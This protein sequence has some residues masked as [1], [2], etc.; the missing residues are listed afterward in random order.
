MTNKH[1]LLESAQ[2][3]LKK[4]QIVKAIKDY[5]KIV[6]LDPADIRS[7]QKLAELY[8]RTNKNMEAY[9][10]YEPV[11][12]HFA[13]NGFYLKAIAIYKQ[14]QRLDPSQISL[15][16]R[17]AELNHK[18]GLL[19][20]ALS[21]YRSLV[22]YYNRNGMVADEIKTLEKMRDLDP[23]NL[24][25]RVKLAEI[26]SHN[27]RKGDGYAEL[28]SVLEVLSEKGGVDK[29][30]RLYKMFL[31]VYPKDKKLQMGL[32]L[33]FYEKG[34]PGRGVTIIESLLK[35]K[36][37]DP[38]L[39]RLLGQGYSDLQD[40]NKTCDIYQQLLDMD[41]TDLNIR[42]AMIKCEIDSAQYALALETLE[43][44]KETFFK[45]DRLDRLQE[46]YEIL[47][48]KLVGNKRIFQTL[49]SIYE[50]NGDGDKLLD[51]IIEQDDSND[52]IIGETLSDSLLGI[53]DEDIDDSVIALGTNEQ[54]L[55]VSFAP[56]EDESAD[57]LLQSSFD[58]ARSGE[59][60][61][62]DLVIELD[63]DDSE[64]LVPEKNDDLEFSFA[65][66]GDDP[67]ELPPVAENDLSSVAAPKSSE[68][69]PD[70]S[71]LSESDFNFDLDIF[72]TDEAA[73]KKIFKTD[74]DEQIAADDMESHYNLG[75]AYR[76]MGLF[77]DAISE[78]GKAESDPSRYVDCL[79]LKGLCFLDKSDFE[80]A[81]SMFH[82]AFDSPQLKDIQRLNLGYELGLLYERSERFSD[83]LSS[84]QEVFAQDNGYREVT[85]KISSLQETLGLEGAA[86]QE[87]AEEKKEQISL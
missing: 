19:G 29:K 34:D 42:E 41:P 25:I 80:N 18:Q 14:M 86:L 52:E 32:A 40:W 74:V 31:P 83:A 12:E 1:K 87:G 5:A 51:I 36:P 70:F 15:I 67:E 75:I 84:Y 50:L 21:E 27:D 56:V 47:K 26:Y 81:K 71:N 62:D 10:Q 48:D 65:T 59:M 85:E 64:E 69:S 57:F 24:N 37:A 55:E 30:L 82:Q 22:D 35:D 11:A 63:I 46:F 58:D 53:I 44:W 77:D 78:F 72:P 2:K 33:T 38:D 13:G 20:N 4:K 61:E 66:A 45:A 3:N 49:D 8:V 79:T 76:E 68:S 16:H 7:R 6:E 17:L 43:E 73:E 54:S 9:E 60:T 39:L 23:N 28:E